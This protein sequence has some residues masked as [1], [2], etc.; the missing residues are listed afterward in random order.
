MSSSPG[1]GGIITRQYRASA[2]T[3]VQDHHQKQGISN[4]NSDAQSSAQSASRL[5]PNEGEFADLNPA[6]INQAVLAKAAVDDVEVPE[7]LEDHARLARRSRLFVKE[8]PASDFDH[9]V[10]SPRGPNHQTRQVI[11]D[12][13]D[14]SNP[15]GKLD[16]TSKCEPERLPCSPAR[17]DLESEVIE[18]TPSVSAAV[19]LPPPVLPLSVRTA[20]PASPELATNPSTRDAPNAVGISSLLAPSNVGSPSN[21]PFVG[22]RFWVDLARPGRANFLKELKV[23][24][25][26]R[27]SNFTDLKGCGRRNLRKLRASH[28][29]ARL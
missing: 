3:T 13:N 22:L 9:P 6:V 21:Q 10:V 24:S 28:S 12:S 26:S 14:S 23:G 16:F 25:A 20:P 2:T 5:P 11:V 7:G 8:E 17:S 19:S 18:E 4:V 1:V 29:C 15:G 27:P